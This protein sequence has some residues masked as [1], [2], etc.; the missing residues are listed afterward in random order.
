LS[1]P[2]AIDKY[3]LLAKEMFSDRKPPGKDGT[4][5]ASKLEK[6]FKD[7]IETK[8]GPGTA[9]EKIFEREESNSICKT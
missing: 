8:L 5:M 2:E 7:V 3:R 6:A 1:V 9:E 4:F